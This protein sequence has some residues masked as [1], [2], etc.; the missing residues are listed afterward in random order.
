MLK[1][2][3]AQKAFYLRILFYL[4]LVASVVL[5]LQ[6]KRSIPLLIATAACMLLGILCSLFSS[7]LDPARKQPL[8]LNLL[9]YI[10]WL[11]GTILTFLPDRPE[12]LRRFASGLLSAGFI[13][14]IWGDRIAKAAEQSHPPED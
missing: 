8:L 1:T 6:P 12:M 14:G 5:V 10:C 2:P 3:N 9:F 4:F 11:G 13:L 7:L